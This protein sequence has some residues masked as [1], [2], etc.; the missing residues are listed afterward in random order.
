[1]S[2]RVAVFRVI[3]VMPDNPSGPDQSCK[4]LINER[5]HLKTPE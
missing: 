2:S 3:A 4:F 1:M 5:R